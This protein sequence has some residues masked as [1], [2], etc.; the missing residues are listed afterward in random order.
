VG[1]ADRNAARVGGLVRRTSTAAQPSASSEWPFRLLLIVGVKDDEQEE[2]D[3]IGAMKEVGLLKRTLVDFGRSI[4]VNVL[5]L[6]D[7]A[8][9][10][11]VLGRYQPHAIHFIG[12]GTYDLGRNRHC[13]VIENPA[14]TWN[15]TTTAI[16]EDLTNANCVPRMV[17][18]NC[19][20]SSSERE[21]NLSLQK[22][23]SDFG[24][25]VVVAMQADVRGDK[26]AAFSKAFYAR[27]LV[28]P[29]DAAEAAADS[30]ASVV[31][32]M[33]QGRRALGA[34]DEIDWALPTL[35]FCSGVSIDCSLMK[36]RQWPDDANFR[37]CREFDAARVYADAGDARRTMI[38][39]FYP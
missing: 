33:R 23:L 21:S 18:L 13:L 3:R 16:T 29:N 36:R 27:A 15:W 28:E 31:D 9:V 20:R 6:P 2:A 38:E 34:E 14:S 17:F 32:A 5:K 26:A 4:D 19:C 1:D 22:A 37:L 24:V 7:Q 12:H 30:P 39:W 10:Q 25:P 35:T 11:K 8:E